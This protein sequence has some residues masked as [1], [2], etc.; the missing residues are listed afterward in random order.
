VKTSDKCA[1]IIVADNTGVA[2]VTALYKDYENQPFWIKRIKEE[3]YYKIYGQAKLFKDKKSILANSAAKIVD[4]N[5]MTHH[6]LSVFLNKSIREKGV[7]SPVEI[8]EGRRLL[9]LPNDESHDTTHEHSKD[10]SEE[11]RLSITPSKSPAKSNEPKMVEIKESILETIKEISN[12]ED[13]AD[14]NEIYK[15][16]SVKTSR[17]KFDVA[18]G[19]LS[20]EM[21]IINTSDTLSSLSIDD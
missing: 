20:D 5:Q 11:V 1:K 19:M 13:K 21:H 3:T 17:A 18:V 15:H 14:V 10:T 8:K 9:K 4:F 16:L 7:L 2:E 12:E 6:F